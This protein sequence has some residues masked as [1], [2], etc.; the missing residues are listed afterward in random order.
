M[1]V[2][3]RFFKVTSGDMISKIKEIKEVNKAAMK[4]YKLF[5]KKIG[6]KEQFYIRDERMVGILFDGEPDRHLFKKVH[7]GWWP[8]KNTKKGKEMNK[9]LEAI[10]TIPENSCLRLVGLSESPSIFLAGKCYFATMVAIPSD[11]P[12]ILLNIPWYDENP[13]KIKKY[14]ED[15]KK[16]VHHNCNMDAILW[17]PPPEMAEIKEWEYMKNI[18]DWNTSLEEA[19]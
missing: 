2:Y 4:K 5:L 3:R 18:D 16:G 15:K 8:K 14:I 12:V 1:N 10:K 6:A 9:E 13:E 7:N 17:K 11:P 19:A